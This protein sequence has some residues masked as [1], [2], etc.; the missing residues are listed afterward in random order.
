MPS[1][2]I[3]AVP[4]FKTVQR[5]QGKKL[6]KKAARTGKSVKE[7][8]AYQFERAEHA[9][10]AHTS[11]LEHQLDKA[12][13]SVSVQP[14]VTCGS[15]PGVESVSPNRVISVPTQHNNIPSQGAPLDTAHYHQQATIT[16]TPDPFFLHVIHP[17]FRGYLNRGQL[18]LAC[19]NFGLFQMMSAGHAGWVTHIVKQQHRFI[20]RI[21]FA[22]QESADKPWHFCYN[23]AR[24]KMHDF[25]QHAFQEWRRHNPDVP[26][27]DLKVFPNWLRRMYEYLLATLQFQD[28][29]PTNLDPQ[30]IRLVTMKQ[31]VITMVRQQY[32]LKNWDRELRMRAAVPGELRYRAEE[33]VLLDLWTGEVIRQPLPVLPTE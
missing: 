15:A 30:M 6:A 29:I 31:M 11:S 1:L 8:T 13:T 5:T 19:Q 7:L 23:L 32:L 12:S 20:L 22:Y 4:I 3:D 27:D 21:I 2:P 24:K 26:F 28:P 14:A 25:A 10:E 16:T 9:V 17:Q 33:N 18:L